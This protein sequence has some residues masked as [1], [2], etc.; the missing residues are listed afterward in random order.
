MGG[1]FPRLARSLC[2]LGGWRGLPSHQKRPQKDH[3][4]MCNMAIFPV[5]NLQHNVKPRVT[6]INCISSL[7]NQQ[8]WARRVK[9]KC[10]CFQTPTSCWKHD[11]RH[12]P[13]IDTHMVWVRL[14][15]WDQHKPPSWL[16]FWGVA[17][18]TIFCWRRRSGRD[19]R[20]VRRY[21]APVT[22]T[23]HILWTSAFWPPTSP[24]LTFFRSL[25]FSTTFPPTFFTTMTI[26]DALGV[27]FVQ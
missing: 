1:Q 8:F 19:Y 22:T 20:Y 6:P 2:Q 21:A 17:F 23:R 16:I 13:R 3:N 14:A 9:H 10:K 26:P 5:Y 15:Q 12:Q 25:I 27:H 7:Q 4:P 11:P 18:L 24:P